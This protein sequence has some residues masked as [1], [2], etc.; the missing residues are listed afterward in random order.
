MSKAN[1]LVV[2]DEKQLLMGLR[3]ILEIAGYNVIIAENGREAVE[4]LNLNPNTPPDMIVSD[5]MMPHMSGFELLQYVRQ[6]ENWVTIPFVFLTALSEKADVHLGRNLGVDEYVIKPF[7]TEDLLVTIEAR[8][9]RHHDIEAAN[10]KTINTIKRQI[11]DIL[12]HEFRTP[13]TLVVA[14]ADM[15]NELNEL[16]I[17]DASPGEVLDFL[18]GVNSGAQR[19]RRLVENFILLVELENGDLQKTYEW[20]AHPLENLEDM[21]LNLPKHVGLDTSTRHIVFNVENGLPHVFGD[22][23]YLIAALRELLGNAFKFSRAG[24]T[25]T[26]KAY[27][28][29]HEVCISITDEGRGIAEH[30]LKEIWKPFY[31]INRN[32]FEDQGAGAGLSIV[33]GI[34]AL[35]RGRVEVDS[36]LGKGSTFNVFLPIYQR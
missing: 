34:V 5:I 9:K 33:Q 16:N 6:R 31:Q 7:D 22:Q 26:I 29:N 3:D 19:L 15:L 20:R 8:L 17:E 36:T 27:A 21:V 13:L 4:I 11:M 18:K 10:A 25:I 28:V 2:E 30:E 14:Y 1:L 12:N 24:T 35:H 23:E 32:L